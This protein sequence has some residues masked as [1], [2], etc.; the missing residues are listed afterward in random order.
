MQK[1]LSSIQGSF[2]GASVEDSIHEP[3]APEFVSIDDPDYSADQMNSVAMDAML[4]GSG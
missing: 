2:D 1:K 3:N 4:N